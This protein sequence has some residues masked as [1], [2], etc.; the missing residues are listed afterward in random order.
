MFSRGGWGIERNEL[1]ESSMASNPCVLFRRALKG[2]LRC[3]IVSKASCEKGRPVEQS[4]H[5]AASSP[6]MRE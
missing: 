3:G 2:S 4:P 1:I 5:V 6:T